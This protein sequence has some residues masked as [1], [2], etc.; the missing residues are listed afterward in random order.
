MIAGY[1]EL[2]SS[3]KFSSSKGG[4][5]LLI[6]IIIG[7]YK[8]EGTSSRAETLNTIINTWHGKQYLELKNDAWERLQDYYADLNK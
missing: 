2:G 3:G 8:G 4:S 1:T 5:N 7:G 6:D